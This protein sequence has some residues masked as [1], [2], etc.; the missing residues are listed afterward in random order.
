MDVVQA[1][2]PNE[3]IVEGP[4]TV[5]LEEGE[6]AIS[7][8]NQTYDCSGETCE[9]VDECFK[10]V[11]IGNL[12]IHDINTLTPP[13]GGN[14]SITDLAGITLYHPDSTPIGPI[15]IADMEACDWITVTCGNSTVEDW[16]TCEPG[17][18]VDCDTIGSYVIGTATCHDD[19]SGWD[20]SNC[21]E[22]DP[23]ESDPC[24]TY[25]TCTALNGTD[26][27]CDCNEGFGYY[28]DGTTCV[29]PCDEQDC[30]PH[31]ECVSIDAENFTCNCES[32][33]GFNGTT[34][35]AMSCGDGTVSGNE[36]CD[37]ADATPHTCDEAG[38]YSS[39]GTLVCESGCMSWDFSSCTPDET[40]V[41]DLFV[42]AGD[43]FTDTISATEPI[44]ISDTAFIGSFGGGAVDIY[45]QTMGYQSYTTYS[46]NDPVVF[47]YRYDQEG[48][49]VNMTGVQAG[50]PSEEMAD[51]VLPVGIYTDEVSAMIFDRIMDCSSG[52]GCVPVYV[53]LKAIGIGEI[54]V[55]QLT[56]LTPPEGGSFHLGDATGIALYHPEATPFG[57]LEISG[58]DNCTRN[59][60]T[61]GNGSV[62]NWEMC[63]QGD[64]VNCD[65]IGPYVIGTASCYND[66]SGWD[67][68]NCYETNPCEGNPCGTYG[69]CNIINE[70]EYSCE[71]D[72][73]Q[74]YYFNGTTCFSPCDGQDCGG[75]G[76]CQ[77]LDYDTFTCECEIGYGFTGTTCE[78]MSCGDGTVSGSEVC[79]TAEGTTYNC[80]DIGGYDSGT[81]VCNP[82]CLS[83]DFSSCTPLP[84]LVGSLN[85][86]NGLY[87]T[88][89]I[90]QDDITGSQTLA[91]DGNMGGASIYDYPSGD[92]SYAF[93]S[94][95]DITGIGSY[96]GSIVSD[97][98]NITSIQ[99]TAPVT[100][101]QPGLI[102]VGDPDGM[103]IMVFNLSYDCSTGECYMIDQCLKAVVYGDMMI[104]NI[105]EL[106][107]PEGGSYTISNANGMTV[108][109]PDATPEGPVSAPE[110]SNCPR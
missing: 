40:L 63:E 37:T 87:N 11:G 56:T 52:T 82:D 80:S 105:V 98:Y 104:S 46:G 64:M 97:L 33:Y 25:G 30:G 93:Y 85:V 69:D 95:D 99:A 43:Y 77:V 106:T 18:E 94:G 83:W 8:I 35:E 24:G 14:F 39:T 103:T 108:Y 55:S 65:E 66:C 90:R 62:Q 72:E 78:A 32:G 57:P 110:M 7:I 71:C 42:L 76:D 9:V 70:T 84:E 51:G 107:P 109:H 50:F 6:V 67:E 20:E 22:T 59:T 5:G 19:C 53:C 21:Y 15:S 49:I 96:R 73:G 1:F 100:S 79:D 34:C 58:M 10:A 88:G 31:G 29:N 60:V 2:F 27:E 74:G 13:E 45:S 41:G 91:F 81:V 3:L 89:T 61:C 101:I 92:S 75:H 86:H 44:A 16:E 23:C 28:F 48:S 38:G 12:G 17:D 26:Y 47:S 102:D 54:T 68:S 36:V 4:V